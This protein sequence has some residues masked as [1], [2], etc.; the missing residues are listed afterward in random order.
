MVFPI[1]TPL[2]IPSSDFTMESKCGEVDFLHEKMISR[3][4]KTKKLIF[5]KKLILI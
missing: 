3:I 2:K 5:L 4:T 1:S